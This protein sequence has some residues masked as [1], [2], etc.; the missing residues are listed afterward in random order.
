MIAFFPMWRLAIIGLLLLS[1]VSCTSK[2]DGDNAGQSPFN[3]SASLDNPHFDLPEIQENGE[4]IIL[5]LYGPES[6]F[7]FRG[8]R[9]GL[10]YMIVQ[11]YAKS[12]GAAVRVDVSRNQHDLISKLINGEGDVVAYNV[13]IS[14]SLKNEVDYLAEKEITHFLDSISH[15]RKDSTL[16]PKPHTA[17]A[18]RKDSPLLSA[19]LTDWMKQHSNNFYAY[20]TIKVRSSGGK[21]YTPRRKVSSPVLN[22]SRGEISLYDNIFKQ[23]AVTCGWDWRLIAAQAFQESAFD[24]QAVSF[25]GAMGLMQL[26]PSTARQVGVS[27]SEVFNPQ[28]N[29]RGATKLI[30]QLNS[31]YSSITNPDERINFILA[32]Y[33]AGPGHVDDARSLARKYGKNPDVWLGNVDFYVLNMSKSEYYNQPEVK[34]GYFRGSETHDYVNSIRTRWSEY[35]KIVR[36]N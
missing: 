20:T 27:Q 33:N 7:E 16:A 32:A 24:P 15:Q 35:K 3:S 22:A 11:E 25:M 34:H 30:S 13:V 12:I 26:M 19:S 4:I 28:S 9:F 23:Y 8:E 14:D 21:V 29:V 10:Q 18:V 2:R 1:I 31:H 5:T 17:W 36:G 6:F